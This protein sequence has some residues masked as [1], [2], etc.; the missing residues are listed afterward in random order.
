MIGLP[1]LPKRKK[2]GRMQPGGIDR[3]VH[4][5][6]DEVTGDVVGWCAR[7][8]EWKPAVELRWR[9][10]CNLFGKEKQGSWECRECHPRAGKYD[11]TGISINGK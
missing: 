8:G 2:A 3:G 7:C 4:W 9:N 5:R 11:V 6:E 10:D 1:A